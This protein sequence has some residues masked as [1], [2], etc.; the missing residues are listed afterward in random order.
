MWRMCCV[1]E[2]ADRRLMGSL[3]RATTLRDLV[4]HVW[5]DSDLCIVVAV[6]RVTE[7]V[8]CIYRCQEPC[9]LLSPID[10]P[11]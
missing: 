8:S 11:L 7:R 9:I 10:A 1:S 5:Q 2:R 3:D 6:T 4:H